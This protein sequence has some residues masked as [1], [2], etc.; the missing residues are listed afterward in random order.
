MF[1][2]FIFVEQPNMSNID[3]TEYCWEGDSTGDS[4]Q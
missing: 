1:I 3:F 2:Y 4:H